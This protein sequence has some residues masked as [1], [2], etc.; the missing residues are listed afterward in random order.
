MERASEGVDPALVH[1]LPSRGRLRE[2]EAEIVHECDSV[3]AQTLC[4]PRLLW[5][6]LVGRGVP[7]APLLEVSLHFPDAQ[8]LLGGTHFL[9]LPEPE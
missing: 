5:I 6:T 1:F 8:L 2:V 9:V 3:G 7:L 4:S